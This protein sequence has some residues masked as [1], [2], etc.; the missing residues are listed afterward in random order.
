M[1]IYNN[2]SMTGQE[3][4]VMKVAD[5]V[6]VSGWSPARTDKFSTSHDGKLLIMGPTDHIQTK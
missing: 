2:N 5:Q 3:W 1:Q 6:P 4:P